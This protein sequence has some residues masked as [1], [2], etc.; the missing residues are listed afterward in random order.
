MHD[1]ELIQRH[2]ERDHQGMDIKD[3][4]GKLHKATWDHEPK[5]SGTTPRATV[6]AAFR[7]DDDVVTKRA[8]EIILAKATS[9]R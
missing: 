5:A 6:S 1:T 7:D 8:W 9:F 3:Y 4:Y 2:L